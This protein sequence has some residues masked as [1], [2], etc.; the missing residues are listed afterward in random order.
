M[1]RVE[2]CFYSLCSRNFYTMTIFMF[3]SWVFEHTTI[4]YIYVQNE[5]YS[6]LPFYTTLFFTGKVSRGLVEPFAK[7]LDL[8][9]QVTE[10]VS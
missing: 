5:L 2:F 6:F 8:L 7:A 4:S 10:I 9:I 1:I 3:S